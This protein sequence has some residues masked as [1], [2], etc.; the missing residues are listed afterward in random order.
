MDVEESE[1]TYEQEETMTPSDQG[2]MWKEKEQ[3]PI[4]MWP[5]YAE[6]DL[7]KV[8]FTK[9]VEL[10]D[11]TKDYRS[12]EVVKVFEPS[13][14]L[15]C[16]ASHEFEDA[17]LPENQGFHDANVCRAKYKSLLCPT[18]QA[19][20]EDYYKESCDGTVNG[21]WEAVIRLHCHVIKPEGLFK[22]QEYM[23]DFRI[24]DWKKV[25]DFWRTEFCKSAH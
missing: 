1:Q 12:S 3:G 14:E 2:R 10:E 7:V 11:G 4:S 22:Q 20:F 8:T 24:A 6:K 19:A 13:A 25:S 23:N 5:K 21:F 18:L 9:K 17:C 15:L 16:R